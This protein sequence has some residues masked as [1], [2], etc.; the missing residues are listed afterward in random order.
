MGRFPKNLIIPIVQPRGQDGQTVKMS[1]I[2]GLDL[3]MWADEVLK[4]GVDALFSDAAGFATGDHCR[5]CPAKIDCPA[6]YALAKKAS[7]VEFGELPPDPMT[8]SDKE[9][10]Q[11]LDGIEILGWWFQE[12]RAEASGRIE[13]G[14]KVPNWKLVPKRATRKWAKPDELPDC[15]PEDKFWDRKVKSPTQVQK[16]DPQ[17]YGE[18]EEGGH[19]DKTSSGTTLAPEHDPRA[20]AKTRSARDEFGVIE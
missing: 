14:K 10:S 8:F 15:L 17:I 2:T 13:K 19:I 7:R 20:A 4:P 12:I 16:I 3:R 5:F 6:L 18:L 9:L 11:V 1:R